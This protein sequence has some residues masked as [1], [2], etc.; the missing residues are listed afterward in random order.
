MGKRT[1]FPHI[2]CLFPSYIM[3]M[4]SSQKGDIMARR[5]W[6]AR[7][8][9][10][11]PG[12]RDLVG[13]L[14]GKLTVVG[15]VGSKRGHRFWRCRCSCGETVE[16]R[17]SSLT[18]GNTKSCGCLS[19]RPGG[20][21]HG[22]AVG[23]YPPEFNIWRAMIRRCTNPDD[24]AYQNYGGRGISVCARWLDS[25]PNFYSDLG[26]RPDP[27]LTLDRIDNDG[28]YEPGNCRWASRKQQNANRRKGLRTLTVKGVTRPLVDW[29]ERIGISRQLLS[30]RI[31]RMG[32][33]V[34]RAV[35]TPAGGNG[36]RGGKR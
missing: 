12:D 29:A 5:R 21:G 25:F 31:D 2:F 30:N 6:G 27:S 35:S 19:N 3:L 9:S 4:M 34:E 14:F 15:L 7:K 20:K 16:V 18:S 26:S 13:R 24:R 10:K 8:N 1:F 17:T 22:L 28:D 36:G 33:N 32:W 11:R 23:G